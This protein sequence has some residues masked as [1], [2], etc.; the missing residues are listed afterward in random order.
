VSDLSLLEKQRLHLEQLNQQLLKELRFQKTQF[1]DTLNI[2]PSLVAYWDKDLVNRFANKAYTSWFDMTPEEMLGKHI[3]HLLGDDLYAA[4]L[5][6]IKGVLRGDIQ[7]F[8][9]DI[10][11]SDRR[12]LRHTIATYIPDIKDGEVIGF[13]VLVDD[14]NELKEAQI[15][16]GIK[17]QEAERLEIQMLECLNALSHTRDNETGNHVVRTQYFVIALARRLM[18]MG[19]YLDLLN[20]NMINCLHKAAPLHDIGKVGIPDAILKK[21]GKLSDEEWGVMMTHTT[22]GESV[23]AAANK[24]ADNPLGLLKIAGEIAGG[25]HEKWDGTGYPRGLL[26]QSIPLPARIMALADMYDALV[27]VRVYKEAWTHEQACEEII[28]KSGTHFD[29]LVV[30]A[31]TLEASHFHEIALKYCDH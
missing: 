22:I 8:E 10:R 9:R 6:F 26:G 21:P 29:P 14:V 28:S 12:K 15:A 4:N 11:G 3:H 18:D 13:Y 17:T 19:K 25:H 30:K 7:K 31:F 23:L 24:E 5:P 1:Q 2:I 20:E 16:V 27:S